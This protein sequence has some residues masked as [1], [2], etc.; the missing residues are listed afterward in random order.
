MA[1]HHS[2]HKSKKGLQTATSELQV[3]LNGQFVPKSEAKISVFD[4]GLLYGDGVFEGI[5]CY[6]CLVFK[7]KEHLTRLR[8]S[9]HTIMLGL[10]LNIEELTDAIIETLK[11]N[12]LRDAYI[13]VVVTRGPGDLGLDP[14]SCKIPGVFKIGRAHV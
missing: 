11:R 4:H 1:I 10:P 5:R 6:N 8:E 7:L 9:A 14:S 13:R 12:H 2:S 3:Y